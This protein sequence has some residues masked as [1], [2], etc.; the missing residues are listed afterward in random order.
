MRIQQSSFVKLVKLLNDGNYHDGT[1]IGKALNITRSAVWK[2]MK[3]LETY[4][5]EID[6]L[7]GKGYVLTNPLILLDKKIIK[8]LL[9]DKNIDIQI[10]ETLATTN[11]FKNFSLKNNIPSICLA[12]QQTQ[13]KGRLGRPWHSPFAQN[14]YFTCLYTFQKDISELAGLSLVVGL[15]I[16]KTLKTYQFSESPLIKWPNDIIYQQQKLAGTLIEIKAEAH[17]ISQTLIGIGV[18]VNMDDESNKNISQPFTSLKYILNNYIDRNHL[19]AILINTLLDYLKKFEQ[20]GLSLFIK[21]WKNIDALY[22]KKITLICNNQKIHGIAKGINA[23]GHLLLELPNHQVKAFS[24]GDT[25]I[26]KI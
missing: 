2:M 25:T 3:K 19:C 23:N 6:S 20:E 7:K 5:I 11:D 10:F 13:G 18:N 9:E 24:S 12:E 26:A 22:N 17:N 14:L 8:S 1:T 21:E 4:G 15:A 16:L